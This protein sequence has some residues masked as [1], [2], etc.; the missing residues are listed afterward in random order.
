MAI[1]HIFVPGN[2]RPV[3]RKN[4]AAILVNL[5]LP[6]ACH[7]RSFEPEVNTPGQMPAN[8]DPNDN[9]LVAMR[10]T[11]FLVLKHLLAIG[12]A[13]I[14]FQADGEELDSLVPGNTFFVS[15]PREAR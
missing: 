13:P 12:V 14:G 6:A 9:V 1:S 11:T 4:A 15:E 8:N 10:A 7:P 2:V 5:H 3:L